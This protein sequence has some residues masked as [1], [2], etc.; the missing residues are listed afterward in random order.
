MLILI[1]F[2]IFIFGASIGSFLNVLIDRLPQEKSINSRSICDHCHR[3]LVW[4]DLIPI[5]SF[6]ILRGKCRYC[7]KKISWFYPL[8]EILTGF[9]FVFVFITNIQYP[10]SNIVYDIRYLIF[11]IR[12][13]LLIFIGW[14][15]MSC[16]IVIF[17]SDLKYHLISDQIQLALFVFSL[18]LLPF[19][20]QALYLSFANHLIAALLVSSPIFFIHFLT[21]GK[22]MGFGDVK[23]AFNIG[24]LLG[25]KGGFLALYFAFVLGGIVGIFLILLGIKKLNS[26]IAFGP[27]LVIG[28]LIV[29]FLKE[30]IFEVITRIYGL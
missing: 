12:N 10:I 4:Y 9:S 7:R 13:F 27:F 28:I 24:F 14:G 8:V 29:F 11:D 23:L 21:N 30:T 20:G 17:F 19:E 16:L 25:I 5:V 22:A 6:F 2:F 1:Y 15:V 26:Q 18:I 3:Q